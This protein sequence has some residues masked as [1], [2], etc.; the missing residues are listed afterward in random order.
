MRK[1]VAYF[2]AKHWNIFSVTATAITDECL[3]SYVRN[4]FNG[5]SYGDLLT[6]GVTGVMWKV[7]ITVITPDLEE[8]RVFHKSDKADIVL[9]YNSKQGLNGHYCSTIGIS[10][11]W[12]PLKGENHSYEVHQVSNVKKHSKLAEEHYHEVKRQ[13]LKSEYD[14]LLSELE[15][16]VDDALSLRDNIT[17]ME[18]ILTD[19]GNKIH[20]LMTKTDLM[21]GKLLLLGVHAHDFSRQKTFDISQL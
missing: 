21:K 5:Y 9:V 8:I 15:E 18:D 11:K 17:K 1:Q 3:E 14:Y 10:E 16:A 19:M 2:L 4:I 6:L 13:Q 20:S 12:T 7:K